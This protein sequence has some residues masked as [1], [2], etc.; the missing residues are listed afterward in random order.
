MFSPAGAARLAG[1]LLVPGAKTI[2]PAF[3]VMAQAD[4]PRTSLRQCMAE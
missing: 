2:S 3:A 1:G 4:A